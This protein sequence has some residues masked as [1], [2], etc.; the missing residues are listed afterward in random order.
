MLPTS[1]AS[2]CGGTT[3]RLAAQARTA[4]T[5]PQQLQ[6]RLPHPVAAGSR[7]LTLEA[8]A[9]A[10]TIRAVLPVLAVPTLAPTS[11]T[12]DPTSTTAATLGATRVSLESKLFCHTLNGFP[13]NGT[14][15]GDP[16]CN[17]SR[18]PLLCVLGGDGMHCPCYD[19][20][21]YLGA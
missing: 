11:T 16:M 19:V 4:T 8:T 1:S 7:S 21:S 12:A 17:I 6:R 2:R 10:S 14:A 20:A 13:H 15:V 18:L 3:C 9:T 5:W